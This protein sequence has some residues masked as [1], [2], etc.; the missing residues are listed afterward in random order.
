MNTF[1]SKGMK[2][3]KGKTYVLPNGTEVEIEM[4]DMEGNKSRHVEQDVE[5]VESLLDTL[6][7]FAPSKKNYLPSE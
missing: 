4:I 3:E 5:S 2:K 6:S 1:T 7:E